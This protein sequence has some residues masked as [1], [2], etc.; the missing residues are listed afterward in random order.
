MKNYPSGFPPNY[1][2]HV[3]FFNVFCNTVH[4]RVLGVSGEILVAGGLQEWPLW[5]VSGA[6]MSKA[7]HGPAGSA[8][9]PPQPIN[10]STKLV[11]PLWKHTW[12]RGKKYGMK[13]G[14]G[15]KN[16]EKHQREHPGQK[17]RRCFIAQQIPLQ[18]MKNPCWTRFPGRNCSPWRARTREN[19]SWRTCQ[20]RGKV[21]E[22]S[23]RVELLHTDHILRLP[24]MHSGNDRGIRSEGLKLSLGKDEGKVF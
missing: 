23:G 4:F 16:S 24:L 2:F 10:P 19:F 17:R 22:R 11:M 8:V 7:Q 9:D 20:S 14:G 6:P 13:R 12:E 5:K 1:W 18:P 21:W 3:L 15:K